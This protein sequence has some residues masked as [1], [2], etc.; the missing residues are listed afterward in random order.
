MP[1]PEFA[2]ISYRGQNT[3][4]ARVVIPDVSKQSNLAALVLISPA[5]AYKKAPYQTR[6]LF[7]LCH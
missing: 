5:L 3:E 2:R 4:T 7:S 1:D 6:R